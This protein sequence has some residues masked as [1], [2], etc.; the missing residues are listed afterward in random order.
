MH[1]KDCVQNINDF[2]L[3]VLKIARTR[4]TIEIFVGRFVFMNVLYIARLLDKH[5]ICLKLCL[6]RAEICES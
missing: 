5:R 4:A 1:N 2:E 3:S 6:S